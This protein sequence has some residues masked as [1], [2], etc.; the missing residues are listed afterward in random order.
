MV[1]SVL[2]GSKT[3]PKLFEEKSKKRYKVYMSVY[4]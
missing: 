1:F 3:T 4:R 2:E